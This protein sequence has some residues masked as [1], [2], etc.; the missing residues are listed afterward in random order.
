MKGKN[1]AASLF[2]GNVVRVAPRNHPN[3]ANACACSNSPK[4]LKQGDNVG[5]SDK[6]SARKSEKYTK[7]VEICD[8]IK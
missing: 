7:K 5:Y 6:I 4:Q 2:Q 1:S 8:K 3:M